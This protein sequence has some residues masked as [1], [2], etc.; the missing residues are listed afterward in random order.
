MTLA[1]KNYRLDAVYGYV[2][3]TFDYEKFNLL[4]GNRVINR[5]HVEKIK[6]SIECRYIPSPIIVNENFEI[7]DGQH[8]YT[9]IK[10]LKMKLYYIVEPGL[11]FK[12]CQL[13]NQT[14]K[15]WTLIDFIEGYAKAGYESY[16]T[17]LNFK[18]IYP[19]IS[20]NR[21]YQY[22]LEDVANPHH[23]SVK[24]GNFKIKNYK[25]ACKN[26]EMLLDYSICKKVW[27]HM[28]FMQAVFNIIRL[29]KY[30]HE[31]MM[32]KLTY[33]ALTIEKCP[34]VTSYY[35]QLSDIYNKR[36]KFEE[37]LDFKRLMLLKR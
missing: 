2:Y 22:L 12:E 36:T 21:I 18:E 16:K 6:K 28:Y 27:L 13:L 20:H 25:L 37:Q 3:E 26:A 8:T 19:G 32:K 1:I 29:E 31:L 15:N 30:D 33:Q 10:E 5:L 11:G 17:F 7:I 34:S 24:A 23:D 9:A 4:E 14:S 35:E